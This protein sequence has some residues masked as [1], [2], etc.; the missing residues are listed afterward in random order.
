MHLY[1]DS[2]PDYSLDEIINAVMES[3]EQEIAVQLPGLQKSSNS[4]WERAY[5]LEGVG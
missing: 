2:L 5:F 4:L 3:S 1:I